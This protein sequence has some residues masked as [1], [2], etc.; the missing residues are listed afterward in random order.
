MKSKF[1]GYGMILIAATLWGTLGI[2]YKFLYSTA[3]LSPVEIVFWRATIASVFTFLLIIIFH[4]GHL[5]VR[6]QNLRLFLGI[7]VIGIAAFYLCYVYAITSIGMGT[8]SVLLYSAPIWVALYGFV[9]QGEKFTQMKLLALLLSILGSVLIAKV[10]DMDQFRINAFGLL[11]GLGSGLAYA[12]FII[13]NKKATLLGYSSWT[14]NAYG[15]GIGALVF[16]LF[17]EPKQL[18]LSISTPSVSIWLILLGIIP[19][20]GGGLAFYTGLQKIPAVNASIVAT[21]EPLV[22]TFLGWSI[23][24]EHLSFA[25]ILGGLSILTAVIL[26]QLPR[27]SSNFPK[28]DIG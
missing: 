25:Q 2:F 7:G 4:R 9:F 20:L 17:Q 19:T 12:A 1:S 24:S 13:L 21:F 27:R 15:L 23:F 18:F 22:A 26:V 8:A 3:N 5:S 10:Y 16:L 11:A 28:A 14:V 6:L